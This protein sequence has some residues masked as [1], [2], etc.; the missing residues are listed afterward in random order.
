MGREIDSRLLMMRPGAF[1]ST[2]GLSALIPDLGPTAALRCAF[3]L[4]GLLCI[5]GIR[6]FDHFVLSEPSY[7]PAVHALG[8]AALL[9]AGLVLFFLA[10]RSSIPA[11]LR[12]LLPHRRILLAVSILGTLL[13]VP[14]GLD[15]IAQIPGQIVQPRHYHLDSVAAI[16]CSTRL[17]LHGRN[18][19]TDL[20]LVDC[21]R[22]NSVP[23]I[24]TTPLQVGAFAGIKYYPTNQQLAQVFAQ[25]SR[26]H[27]PQP[28]EFES[29]LS[30]PAGS[31]IFPAPLIALGWP[32]VSL[33]YL[34]CLVLTYAL[35]VWWAPPRLRPWLVL[36][37]LANITVWD[38]AFGIDTG[39]L[40][41]LLILAAWATWRRR[42]L[43]ALLM[44]AA[45][46]TRQ[47]AWFFFPFYAILV[48]RMFGRRALTERLIVIAVVFGLLNGPFFLQS[49]AA[50]V[51]G[52]LIQIKDPMFSMGSGFIAAA[53]IG[54]L[55]LWPRSTYAAL[56][57]TAM[58]ACALVYAR[59][60]RRHPGTASVL[61]LVPLVFAWRSPLLYF[62]PLTLLCLWPLVADLRAVDAGRLSQ[63]RETD[64]Q[65]SA[66]AMPTSPARLAQ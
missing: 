20:R 12:G 10:G 59:T 40:D 32:E 65:V 13:L 64:L 3:Y 23:P 16:D 25:A 44:G 27:V 43:S 24:D 14:R 17:L 63:R 21:L 38:Y 54:W 51:S 11:V 31:I 49:P 62:V 53:D 42:W 47:N 39:S 26:L 8:I 5:G 6:V 48:G 28:A 57:L 2:H 9:L 45:I 60:C 7:D 1:R 58:V 55:P 36:A 15:L 46:A 56:E 50:W 52:V 66:A 41:V 19:Y 4:G 33:F 34:L 22:H 37:A 35:L 29:H 30:Y 61:A 18:P